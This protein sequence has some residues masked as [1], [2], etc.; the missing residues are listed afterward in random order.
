MHKTTFYSW[1][2]LII[3]LFS[4]FLVFPSITKAQ[5]KQSEIVFLSG[6]DFEHP[7]EWEFMCTGGQNS[8][9]WGTINVP[10]QWE[11]QGYGEYTY[12][13]WYKELKQKNP[14]MEEGLYKLNFD[15]PQSFAKKHIDIVFE[16]VMT[17]TE[18]KVNGQLV[19]A[20]HQGGFYRFSYDITSFLKIGEPNLLEVHVYKHSSNKSVNRAERYTD[21][22]LFGGIYRPVKLVVSPE[23]YIER[24][25]LDPKADGLLNSELHLKGL[26]EKT[27]V[28]ISISSA[29]GSHFLGTQR[30]D[31]KKGVEK[32]ML[33]SKWENVKP[34][35]IEEPNLY[36][37]TFSLIQNGTTIHQKN[38]KIGFRTLEFKKRDGIYLN[39]TKLLV[40]GINRHT[41]W[42]ESGRS[43][44]KR[45]SIL[46]GQLIKDMNINT[47]RVHYP[48]DDHFLDVCDSMGILMMN[49]LAGWQNGY[50]DEVGSQLIHEMISRDVN[51][52][53]VLTWA[54]GNEGGWNYKLDYLF[55]DLDPQK[56]IVIHP[57]SDFNGWDT[58]HYPAYQT[59]VHRLTNG[60]NVFL[61]TEFM[62]GLYDQGHGAGLKDFW[63]HFKTSPLFAGAVMWA[64]S[65]EAVLRTDWTGDRKY[66]SKGHLAPDGI[67]GPHREK[68]GSYFTV[69]EVWSPIQ[70][71]P[72]MITASFD[73]TFQVSNEFLFT[74]LNACTFK[75]S[76]NAAAAKVLTN[77]SVKSIS[78]GFIEIPDIKPGE[79]RLIKMPLSSKFFEGDWVEIK[80]YDK[81][82]EL[83]CN[84]T[85][86]IHRAD[87]Y[88]AKFLPKNKKTNAN[89]VQIDSGLAILEK[90]NIRVELDTKTGLLTSVKRGEQAI[91]FLNGP[92]PIGMQAEVTEVSIDKK[93][94]QESLLVKYKGGIDNIRWTM[95][96]EGILKMD[97]TA[98]KAW[99]NDGGFDGAVF[100]NNIST[101]GITFDF[102]EESVDGMKWFGRGPYR[103]WKN[104]IPGTNYGVWQKDYNNTITGESFENLIYPEFKGYHAHMLWAQIQAKEE[105]FTVVSES[106][107]VFLRML[108]PDEPHYKLNDR[109]TMPGFPEG[110]ISFMYE[111]PAIWA[112][113]PIAHQGPTSQPTS[114]RIKSGD[115]GIRMKLDFDFR[116]K[117]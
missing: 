101:F 14:S 35:N 94:G 48:P 6:V 25:A 96:E 53:C 4:F 114:I 24:L 5:D 17:D 95:T 49:E 100:E 79:T 8:G 93:D 82:N 41:F 57:W 26:K 50:D 46:D 111:I 13:R 38:E 20:K 2:A 42:P 74:N 80:A 71:K 84:W 30:F 87:Y 112:F 106:D 78:E 63:D 12:G 110:D 83:I 36:K 115:D 15:V 34:W 16:G 45:L 18:V 90:H 103:V 67:L 116:K 97:M 11:L 62:H 9:E 59:G 23:T 22:W 60:E 86:P 72:R 54:Q 73:G 7:K 76:V 43:T 117:D 32:I 109:R 55:K 61:P 19:G 27:K 89:T 52:P 77:G 66:D 68:E 99:R 88:A 39:G 3:V 37:V 113:K 33:S 102:P 51:H 56:R 85:W 81:K 98:L 65:D 29:D 1:P 104:R 92:L 91:P 10:S 40:K 58:H 44:S 28:E 47:V 21:W 75:Y 64:Y 105:S 69:K 31:V 70:F 107:G 108:T